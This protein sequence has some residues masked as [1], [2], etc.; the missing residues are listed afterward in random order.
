[1]IPIQVITAEA[2]IWSTTVGIWSRF[3]IHDSIARSVIQ[4]N[5]WDLYSSIRTQIRSY[6]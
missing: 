2:L 1:M 5:H 3:E 6:S 4:Q